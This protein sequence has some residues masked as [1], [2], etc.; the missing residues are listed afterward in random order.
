M[1]IYN[2]LFDDLEGFLGMRNDEADGREKAA[3]IDQ[4]SPANKH[5]LTAAL[6]AAHSK[7]HGYYAT[8]W[9]GMYAIAVILDPRLKMDYYKVNNWEPELV[10]HAKRALLHAIEVYEAATPPSDHVDIAA[11]AAHTAH[12][13]SRMDRVFQAVKRQR[14]QEE[15]EVD[16]YLAGNMADK[17]VNVLEWWKHNSDT[18]PCLARIARDYLAIPATSAP[19]ERAFSGGV[20]LITNKRGSLKG[21]TIR[22]CMCLS[23][24]L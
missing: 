9:A 23:S 1:P 6:Q 22:A 8:L 14:T 21:D 15:S 5:A 20:D 12:A 18:Y 3:L 7:L 19:A 13:E 11:H 17:N 4:C 2:C 16:S 24:W 10:G